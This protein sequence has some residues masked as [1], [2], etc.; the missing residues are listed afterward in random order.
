MPKAV[1]DKMFMPFKLST[2]R[3]V[4]APMVLIGNLQL[5]QASEYELVS[6]DRY[7]LD[8]LKDI[9]HDMVVLWVS[10]LDALDARSDDR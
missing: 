1:L 4:N 9:A 2:G 8:E 7:T 5:A 3:L 6:E 10:Y